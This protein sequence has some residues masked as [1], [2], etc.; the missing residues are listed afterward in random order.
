MDDSNEQPAKSLRSSTLS[1]KLVF[2]DLPKISRRVTIK[3]GNVIDEDVDA[4]VNPANAQLIHGAGVAADIDRASNGEVQKASTKMISQH[5]MLTVRNAV[6]TGAGGM[7]KCNM[8]IHAVGPTEYQ[9]KEKCG[10]LLQ[11]ACL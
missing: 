3:L 11:V 7:L 10:P 1:T 8:I 9:H 4:I 6:V 2:I 5:G